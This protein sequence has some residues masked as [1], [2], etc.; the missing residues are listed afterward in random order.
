MWGMGEFLDIE[1]TDLSRGGSGVGR[2]SSGRVIF[3]PKTAPGDRVRVRIVKA[4]KRYAEAELVEILTPSAVRVEPRC[5]AF[6][7]CGGCDWQHLPYELQWKTKKGGVLHALSRVQIQPPSAPEE[8]PAEQIW[9]YR[10]RV[11]LRGTKGQMGF[12][13]PRSHDIIPL[14]RC[15]I[16]RPE[17]NREW[18]KIREEGSKLPRP[19]K[20]EVEV[21]STGEVRKMW[22]AGHA[23]GGFRQVHDAQNEK[24]Q[25][26]VTG[27]VAPGRV[28]LDL[29]GG[30]GNLSVPLAERMTEVHCVDLS[31]PAERPE[32]T[33]ANLHFHRASVTDWLERAVSQKPAW[34]KV[35]AVSAI[36]DPPR[37]G[38]GQDFQ[39]IIPALE[40]LGVREAVFV[41][42]DTDSWARDLSR[43]AR[44]GW[45][46]QRVA[47]LDLFPQTHHVESLALLGL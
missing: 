42:C 21:L 28:L 6:G 3:V 14:D 31:A 12:Y 7:R 4:D 36:L 8:L 27:A 34:A 35:G 13:A 2:D 22:N 37:I 46:L 25:R 16:A 20:V 1:I 47:V 40:Q 44:R 43:M 17:I 18:S 33:P 29:F 39:K 26:W 19:Y 32:G 45:K 41:G 9:E 5:P 15:D 10:N 11:Q 30:S 38:L 23:A 24:L